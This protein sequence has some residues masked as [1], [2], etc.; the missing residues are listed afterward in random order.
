[1]TAPRLLAIAR[2]GFAALAL[3]AI[4]YPNG[5][6]P[7][8]TTTLVILESGIVL[9]LVV[10]AVGNALG[11]RRARRPTAMEAPASRTFPP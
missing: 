5:Y 6:G 7:V 9:C 4:A 2:L 3:F 8:F 11:A 1:M 10:A